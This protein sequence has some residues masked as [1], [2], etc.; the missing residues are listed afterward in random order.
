MLASLALVS[1]TIAVSLA[2]N[3]SPA[4]AVSLASVV[5]LASN[6][7]LTRILASVGYVVSLASTGQQHNKH[8]RHKARMGK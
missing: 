6:V 8:S 7:S 3:V 5:S 2:S 1:L 4:S